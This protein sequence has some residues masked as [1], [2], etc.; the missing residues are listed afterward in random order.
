VAV[1]E[2]CFSG[3][4]VPHGTGLACQRCDLDADGDVDQSD[5]GVLQRCLNGQGKPAVE[6]CES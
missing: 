4:G 5:F 1:F 6:G 3:A 2:E